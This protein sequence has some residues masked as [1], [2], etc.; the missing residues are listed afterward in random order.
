MITIVTTIFIYIYKSKGALEARQT[1]T[2]ES[3]F[4]LEKLQVMSKDYTIDYEEYRNRQ[5]VGCT[6]P[7]NP[8]WNTTGH[9]TMMTYYGNRNM[10]L[11]AN[12]LQN[13]LY[14]C[15][16]K[17][18]NDTLSDWILVSWPLDDISHCINGLSLGSNDPFS[19]PIFSWFVQSYGQYSKMFIDVKDDVDYTTGAVKDD[20]DEALWSWALAIIQSGSV[21]PQEL[22]LISNDKERRLFFRR[23]LIEQSDYNNDGFTWDSEKLYTIQVLQLKWFDAGSNHDFD[24]ANYSWVYDGVIDTWACDYGLWFQCNGQSVSWAYTD[25]RLPLDND[26]GRQDLLTNDITISSRDIVISPLSDPYLAWKQDDAQINPFFSIDFTA[27]LYGKNW[28]LK[29]PWNQMDQ[30]NLKLQTTFSTSPSAAR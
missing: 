5:Q 28:Y 4:F 17:I 30:Y 15:S 3:Y 9:C 25:F 14:Y 6:S 1:V 16:T 26:D 2:K 22:Y 21:Y 10:L 24:T 23:K 19:T 20:D 8:S 29:I 27:K 13:E 7:Q 12:S 18:W 11:N